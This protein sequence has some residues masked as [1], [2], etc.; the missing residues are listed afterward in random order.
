MSPLPKVTQ[1]GNGEPEGEP[2][3]ACLQSL[4]APPLLEY[5]PV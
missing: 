2:G 4:E 3:A 1:L 5:V